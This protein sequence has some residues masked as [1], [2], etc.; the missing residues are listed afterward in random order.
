[1]RQEVE[2]AESRGTALLAG[3]GLD[4]GLVE[5]AMAAAER[6]PREDWVR[7]GLETAVACAEEDPAAARAAL[8]ELR[9]DHATLARLEACLTARP[10]V[11][12]ERA[13]LALG[14]AI[15]LAAAELASPT[16]DLRRRLPE[17]ARWLRCDW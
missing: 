5:R 6:A 11:R 8:W 7:A 1:M 16:P 9:G 4:K 13:T 15:Q 3:G 17:L 14:A 12:S 2:M 10:G